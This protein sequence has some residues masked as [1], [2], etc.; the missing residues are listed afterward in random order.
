MKIPACSELLQQ[1]QWV[2][3]VLQQFTLFVLKQTLGIGF[4]TAH[5]DGGQFG[6]SHVVNST[7][8]IYGYRLWQYQFLINHGNVNSA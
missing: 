7:Y 1:G 3:G 4:N 8:F 5:S 2:E 6:K